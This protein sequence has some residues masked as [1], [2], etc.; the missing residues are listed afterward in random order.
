M[1]A[2]DR[3]WTQRMKCR[4]KPLDKIDTD[5]VRKTFGWGQEGSR[6]QHN[7]YAAGLCGGCETIA[8]CGQLALD[9]RLDGVYA[10]G[11]FIPQEA[12]GR[13]AAWKKIARLIGADVTPR[14]HTT[15]PTHCVQCGVPVVG[16]NKRDEAQPGAKSYGGKGLCSGC[17][18]ASRKRDQSRGA[19]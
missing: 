15:M 17:Y 2:E 4:D 1:R 12:N 18:T 13:R 7:K 11:V 10:A 14:L 16:H 3:E 19:A 8:E 9:M 6:A 5:R